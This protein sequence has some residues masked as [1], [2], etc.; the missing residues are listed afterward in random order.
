M[1]LFDDK[2][3]VIMGVDC[4][5]NSFAFSVF[6]EQELVKWGEIQ[7]KGK[8]VFQRLSDGSKKVR[9]LGEE[10]GVDLVVI[11]SAIYVQNK[12]SVISLA[13]AFGSIIS[14]LM[15]EGSDVKEVGPLVWQNFIGNKPLTKTE[16]EKIIKEFPG[17]SKS[18]YS[19]AGRL[20]RKRR[21]GEW[22]KNTFGI[23]VDNDNVT[24]AIA[25]GYYGM[26]TYG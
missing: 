22:V 24:D 26:K 8:G 20:E 9:S 23:E 4:S 15:S 13:Y 25:L 1:S 2:P 10:L 16:K 14:A 17:K 12:K 19:N 3:S 21:T 5:T 6:K 11:E 7:F 18:W